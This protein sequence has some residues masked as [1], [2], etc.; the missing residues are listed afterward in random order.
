MILIKI[1]NQKEGK[2]LWNVEINNILI[3]KKSKS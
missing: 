2:L 3:K 1:I